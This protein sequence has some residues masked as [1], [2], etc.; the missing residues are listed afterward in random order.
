MHTYPLSSLSYRLLCY[1]TYAV[2]CQLVLLTLWILSTDPS[3]CPEVVAHRFVPLLEYPIM[4]IALLL[5]GALLID[6]AML[7]P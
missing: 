1:G 5:S 4:S 3:V 7:S 2:L 6:Y